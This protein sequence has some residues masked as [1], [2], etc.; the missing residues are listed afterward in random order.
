MRHVNGLVLIRA[1]REELWRGRL[2]ARSEASGVNA[3]GGCDA[4]HGLGWGPSRETTPGPTPRRRGGP[5]IPREIGNRPQIQII[6]I[7]THRS[8]SRRACSLVAHAHS[9]GCVPMVGEPRFPSVSPI[10]PPDNRQMRSGVFLHP[11]TGTSAHCYPT[12]HPWPGFIMLRSAQC[13]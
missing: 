5:S 10:P 7:Y 2:R 13:T 12:C 1:R 6:A 11:R 3:R 4:V 8:T 9:P